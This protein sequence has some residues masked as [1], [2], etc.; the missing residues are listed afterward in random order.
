L[1]DA[2]RRLDDRLQTIE[3]I[4]TAENPIGVAIACL[5]RA[6]S[7]C[8]LKGSSIDDHQPPSR[9]KFYLDK[10]NGKSWASVR[11]CRL[12]RLDVTLVRIMFVS[13]VFMSGGDPAPLFHRGFLP[14]TSP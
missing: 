11:H 4:M 8:F 9:T 7:A 13:A 14:T 5:S 2:A 10:R 1:H 3:R 12:H 6:G